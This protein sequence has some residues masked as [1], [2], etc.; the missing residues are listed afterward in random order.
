MVGERRIGKIR[1]TENID[2]LV[3][4]IKLVEI[5]IKA[6]GIVKKKKKVLNKKH[7]YILND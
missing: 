7:M 3:A 1:E 2:R 5:K 4:E 6:D